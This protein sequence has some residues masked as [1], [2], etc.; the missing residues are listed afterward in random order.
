MILALFLGL[1]V[2]ILGFFALWMWADARDARDGAA[3]AT[4]SHGDHNVALP[5][6]SFAGQVGDNAHGARRGAPAIERRCLRF[7]RAIS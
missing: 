4:S 2:V 5:L 1:L 7:P 3:V 6:S